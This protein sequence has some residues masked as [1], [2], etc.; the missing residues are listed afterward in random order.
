MRALGY[1]VAAAIAAAMFTGNHLSAQALAEHSAAAAG[2][3]AAGI[4]G[5]PVSESIGHLMGNGVSKTVET[6]KQTASST[7]ARPVPKAQ[8]KEAQKP[9]AAVETQ[10]PISASEANTVPAK[11]VHHPKV[12]PASGVQVSTRHRIPSAPAPAQR[13]PLVRYASAP[14]VPTVAD[15]KTIKP[16]ASRK[17]VV[18]KLG[19]P[20]DRIQMADDDGHL[21]EV[22]HYTTPAA[23]L[24]T[25]RVS[26]GVVTEVIVAN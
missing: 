4:A 23:D 16:G 24:G 18:A 2:G 26:D 21:S 20:A 1:F 7:T 10:A 19:P 11:P 17:E 15:L 5:K 14:P 6:S 8:P 9:S 22:M 3:S 25:V 13:P 12:I